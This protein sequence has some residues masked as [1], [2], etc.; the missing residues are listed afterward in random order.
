MQSPVQKGIAALAVLTISLTIAGCASTGGVAPQD[1]RNG[2]LARS[3]PAPPSAP[4]TPTRK[5]PAADWWRAYNDPQLNDVGRSA[6]R[7]AIRHSR[8]RRRACARRSRMV[9]V[10]RSALSPQVNGNL[11]DR[12]AALARQRLLRPGPARQRDHV[13]Q[14]RHARPLVS[15]RPLGQGQE[16][17]R[18]R[19]RRRPRQRRRRPR[20]AAR[21]RSERGARVYRLVD[22]LRA[23]RYRQ[24]PRSRNSSR[25]SI[26][27]DAPSARAASARSSN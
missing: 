25:S 8:S 6:R 3:M 4:P 20:R 15:P 13:E 7:P 1:T 17:R 14:H 23:A 19:A 16:R 24:A 10:A 2:R 5:W 21:T 11:L 22:G 18:A 26:S 9:G 27:R 12:A